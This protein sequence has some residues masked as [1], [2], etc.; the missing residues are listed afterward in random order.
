ML[1]Q[2]FDFC[3]QIAQ[4]CGALGRDRVK[5]LLF[6]DLV[7]RP[8]IF[9]Q[10]LG[11]IFGQDLSKLVDEADQAENVSQTRSRI[12]LPILAALDRRLGGHLEPLLPRRRIGLSEEM[13][14]RLMEIYAPGNQKLFEF[15]GLE[16]RYGYY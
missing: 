11:E 16:N 9:M 4:L 14:R 2:S 15:L 13:R 10:Q 1:L 8:Q 12:R 7:Q 6:E 5:V 3:G